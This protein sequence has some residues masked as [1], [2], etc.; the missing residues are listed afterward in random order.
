MKL[1]SDDEWGRFFAWRPVYIG[2]RLSK[3]GRAGKLS[4]VWLEWVERRRA[5][6][7]EGEH[8]WSYWVYRMPGTR[9]SGT[10]GEEWSR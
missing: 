6:A 5:G 1:R 8:V 9:I 3:D 10:G 4:T 7:W 2:N